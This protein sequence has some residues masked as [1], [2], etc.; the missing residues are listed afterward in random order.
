M[1]ARLMTPQERH[2]VHVQTLA[3]HLDGIAGDDDALAACLLAEMVDTQPPDERSQFAAEV[4]ACRGRGGRCASFVGLC[5]EAMSMIELSYAR[6]KRAALRA[7]DEAFNECL[8][9]QLEDGKPA[10][11]PADL[12]FYWPPITDDELKAEVAAV[13]AEGCMSYAE[14]LDCVHVAA[15]DS[16]W[17]YDVTLADRLSGPVRNKGGALHD[18]QPWD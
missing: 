13:F 3:K 11:D 7:A 9:S 10:D 8:M 16:N 12:G 1:S 6:A 2:R 5:G 15:E 14:Y 4:D 18:P 17:I